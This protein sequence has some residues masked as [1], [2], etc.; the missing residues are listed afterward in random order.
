MQ[1]VLHVDRVGGGAMTVTDS[2]FW[3]LVLLGGLALAR[4][5]GAS[6]RAVSR[7]LMNAAAVRAGFAAA[8]NRP[9]SPG[10]RQTRRIVASAT[11]HVR[12]RTP[13]RGEDPARRGSDATR[14]G[15]TAR[16]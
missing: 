16:S 5:Y 10:P 2:A 12:G 3:G 9:R 14:A 13:G 11:G 8:G 1:A 6:W 7:A 15:G 4:W